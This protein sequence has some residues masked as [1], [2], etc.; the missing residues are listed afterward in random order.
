MAHISN[1]PSFKLDRKKSEKV[2]LE[3]IGNLT[4]GDFY[5]QSAAVHAGPVERHDDLRAQ[6]IASGFFLKCL[7]F[8]GP[9]TA[10]H[11]NTTTSWH[12]I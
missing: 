6:D 4:P 11:T 10:C 3:Y 9:L 8:K 5:V 7:K 1:T 12:E 2:Q